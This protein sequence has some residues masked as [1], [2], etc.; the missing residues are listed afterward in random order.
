MARAEVK[1][2]ESRLRRSPADQVARAK[3]LGYYRHHKRS[4]SA[5]RRKYEGHALWFVRNAPRSSI[6]GSPF[7]LIDAHS[8]A[9]AFAKVKALWE[10]HL[11]SAP[12]DLAL[13][14]NAASYLTLGDPKASERLYL[15]AIRLAPKDSHWREQLGSLY[16]LMSRGGTSPAHRNAAAK[17]LRCYEEARRLARSPVGRFYQLDHLAEFA[18]AAG[19]F[20]RARRYALEALRVAP[21]F[22]DNWNYGNAVHRGHQVLGRLALRSG[23]LGNARRELLASGQVPGSPQLNSFG[24]SFVL[25]REMLSEGEWEVVAEYLTEVG[26]FWTSGQ[27]ALVKWLGDVRHRRMP[28]F[29]AGFLYREGSRTR[30]KSGP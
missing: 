24:P 20:A 9:P 15:R 13:I 29:K 11:R 4:G 25:A 23:R 30:K 3:I 8:D 18:F 1:K 7:A 14:G 17:A 5:Q 12:K 21:T 2:L 19:K 10:Q 26:A 27:G 6:A 22:V 28:D 16:N